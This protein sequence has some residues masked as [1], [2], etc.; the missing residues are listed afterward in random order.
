M[1]EIFQNS[2]KCQNSKSFNILNRNEP[3]P[4]LKA[5]HTKATRYFNNLWNSILRKKC[6]SLIQDQAQ[7]WTASAAYLKPSQIFFCFSSNVLKCHKKISSSISKPVLSAS[8]SI[9]H[10]CTITFQ[11][12]CCSLPPYLIKDCMFLTVYLVQSVCFC[13]PV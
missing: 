11:S 6:R 1:N 13:I 5:F 4:T 7:T 9:L 10:D 8:S 3:K 12:I 2:S